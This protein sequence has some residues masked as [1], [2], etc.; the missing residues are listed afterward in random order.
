MM[1]WPPRLT[2]SCKAA[3][4]VSCLRAQ[5]G[6]G[7][8][9]EVEAVTGE[10][11]DHEREEGFAVRLL[12]ERP[13]AISMAIADFLDIAGEVV[14][15]FG[16]QEEAVAAGDHVLAEPELAGQR[17]VVRVL[18]F[19]HRMPRA[20]FRVEAFGDS[21]RFEEGR[22]ARAV[23]AD[24]EGH[25]RMQFEQMQVL[26]RRDAVRKKV[27]RLDKLAAERDGFEE[28][29]IGGLAVHGWLTRNATPATLPRPW[30]NTSE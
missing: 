13:L 12:V 17:F 1:N 3:R 11:V 29:R 21:H 6:F 8:V 27:E 14:E 9:E 24:E 26:D 7:L 22:F 4:N 15:A 23:V 30:P 2:R 20:A 5:G 10:A 18:G 25:A 28:R 19:K 16:P